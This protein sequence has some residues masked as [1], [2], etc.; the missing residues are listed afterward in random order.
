VLVVG[1]GATGRQIAVELAATRDVLLSTGRPRRVSPERVLGRSLFWWLDRL[2]ILGASRESRIGRYL[3]EADP[4]PGK[5]LG[6]ERL[7][8]RGVTVVGRLVG[9]EGHRCA[10]AGGE[11]AEVGA[12]V[13]ATGYRD[14]S[15]WVAIPEVKGAAGAFVHRR[16]VS[17]VPGLYFIGRSWQWTRGS[18]LLHGVGNDASYV[19][20]RIAEQL[21][22]EVAALPRG[23]R[24]AS[25]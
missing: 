5:A 15:A 21:D 25:A 17:P 16:G 9:A 11:V 13:W 22:G 4:F 6:L 3:M 10:F 1:D 18:A 8:P 19:A 2:G 12:V 23:L 7:R 14:D 24:P 20:A